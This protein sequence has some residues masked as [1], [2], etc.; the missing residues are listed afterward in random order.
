ME[1][2]ENDMISMTGMMSSCCNHTVHYPLQESAFMQ[3]I[4]DERMKNVCMGVATVYIRLHMA[5]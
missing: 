5:I 3:I 4:A 1:T 2:F